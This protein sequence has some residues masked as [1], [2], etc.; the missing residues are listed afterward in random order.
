VNK[1]LRGESFSDALMVFK[2]EVYK[3]LK[4]EVV[5]KAIER[6]IKKR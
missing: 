2:V 3:A 4:I 5:V 1:E 6:V